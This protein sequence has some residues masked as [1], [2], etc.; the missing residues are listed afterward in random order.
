MHKLAHGRSTACTRLIPQPD[1]DIAALIR[2][3]TAR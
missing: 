1:R 2:G 3:T